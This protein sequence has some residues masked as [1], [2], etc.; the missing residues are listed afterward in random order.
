MVGVGSVKW[1]NVG[2]DSFP[3]AAKGP[4]V[5]AR[6]SDC[7]QAVVKSEHQEAKASSIRGASHIGALGAEIN[8]QWSRR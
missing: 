7:L 1:S 5:G 8:P 2:G 3:A 4:P 6:G